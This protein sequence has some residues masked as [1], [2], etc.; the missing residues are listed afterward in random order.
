MED[1]LKQKLFRNTKSG[2]ENT[3]EEQRKDIE[4]VSKKYMDFLNKAKIEREFITNAKK[5]ADENGYKDIMEL[6]TLK[7]G[8]K[9]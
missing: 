3:T 1:E 5:L 7:P 2:W 6:E 8:D 9:I 4:E